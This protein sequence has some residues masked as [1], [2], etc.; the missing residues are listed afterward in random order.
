MQKK[1]GVQKKTAVHESASFVINPSI[2]KHK[3]HDLCT[4]FLEV[5]LTPPSAHKLQKTRF[6]KNEKDA[7][8]REKLKIL[9][10]R[11]HKKTRR[12]GVNAAFFSFFFIF[13][14]NLVQK[15]QNC[16]LKRGGGIVHTRNQSDQKFTDL[17]S[18]LAAHINQ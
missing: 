6:F 16:V 3:M 15:I 8:S 12:G 13:L 17:K 2:K 4:H 7:E 1:V 14:A 10:T 9:Y 11:A 18:R 5:A